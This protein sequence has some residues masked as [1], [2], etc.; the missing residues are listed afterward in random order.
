M[1]LIAN[2]APAS[3]GSCTAGELALTMGFGQMVMDG[4]EIDPHAG[5]VQ[6]HRTQNGGDS[7]LSVSREGSGAVLRVEGTTFYGAQV[8][9]L[10]RCRSANFMQ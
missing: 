8:K 4:E 7:R 1:L 3:G 2:G 6:I 10:L 5:M 9:A